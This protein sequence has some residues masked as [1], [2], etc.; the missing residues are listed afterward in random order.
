MR[1]TDPRHMPPDF[2]FD[3]IDW[4]A[5]FQRGKNWSFIELRPQTLCGFAPG[6]ADEHPARHRG[7][8]RDLQGAWPA[9][10]FSRQ[11]RRLRR[12]LP[13]DRVVALRQCRLWAATE[14]RCGHEAYNITN[15]DYFRWH[16]VWPK[17]AAVFDMKVG[18]VRTISLTQHMA[19]KAR[20]WAQLDRRSTASRRTPIDQLVAWPFADYV[21]AR[22]WDVMSDVTKSAAR[23]PR[24]G[25]QRGD[26]RAPD[27]ALP[28]RKDRALIARLD[29]GR[30]LRTPWKNGGGVSIDIA[31]DGEVWRFG[32]TPITA[33]GPF[34]DYTGFDRM[35]VLVAGGGLVLETPD[36]E[37]DVRRPFRPVRFAGETGS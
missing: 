27:A 31:S 2:Y 37:I 9:A 33:A 6:T 25:R 5:D 1:E 26:V 34:S 15:G 7:L 32:R 13:G 22:D 35:Q 11:A 4:L 16:N 10:A 8:R 12:D 20:L 3:Q 21:F 19:D 14:P 23:L 29:P 28:P 30:Y 17:L 24:R 18:E 36:G